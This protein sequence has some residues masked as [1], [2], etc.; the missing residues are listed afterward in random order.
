[1]RAV[2][3][4]N[5]TV[6]IRSVSDLDVEYV[7]RCIGAEGDQVAPSWEGLGAKKAGPVQFQ[8][9]RV[10]KLDCGVAIKAVDIAPVAPHG[11]AGR[12]TNMAGERPP[13]VCFIS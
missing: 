7:D 6:E 13:A 8:S 12:L 9:A 5:Q 10:W 1:M 4:P 3:E 2:I 11:R